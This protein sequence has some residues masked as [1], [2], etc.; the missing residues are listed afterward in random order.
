MKLNQFLAI[1]A[2]FC[3]TCFPLSCRKGILNR[4]TNKATISLWTITGQWFYSCGRSR[5]YFTYIDI[6]WPKTS[7]CSKLQAFLCK[8]FIDSLCI[9]PRRHT[10]I[11][12]K[13]PNQVN[14]FGIG[15][16]T[17][18]FMFGIPKL[19]TH[20]AKPDFQQGPEPGC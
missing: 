20:A 8:V 2:T 9:G 13:S 4:F 10:Y 18:T 11:I 15:P 19:P 12:Q 6:M 5:C 14:L 3:D 16:R 1:W 17:H 7:Q